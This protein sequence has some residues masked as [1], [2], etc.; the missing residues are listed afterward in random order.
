[1]IGPV[2]LARGTIVSTPAGGLVD[3]VVPGFDEQQKF[4]RCPYQQGIDPAPAIGNSCLV[5]F[6]D[7]HAAWVIAWISS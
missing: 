6:D 7:L 5:A 3:V 4:S 2:P 1:V